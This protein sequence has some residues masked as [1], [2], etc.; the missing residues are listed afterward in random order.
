MSET[1][2]EAPAAC[3]YARDAHGYGHEVGDGVPHWETASEGWR[4]LRLLRLEQPELQVT[5]AREAA[6][7]WHLTCAGCGYVM[8]EDVWITHWP[9]REDAV[10][11]A[12]DCD[13]TVDG[14]VAYCWDCTPPD[15]TDED[16]PTTAD[17]KGAGR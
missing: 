10:Q 7:C 17:E 15:A 11:C 6:P 14:D 9:S 5:L 8:D 3:F 16:D 2:T 13:W 1:V 12:T 4:Q